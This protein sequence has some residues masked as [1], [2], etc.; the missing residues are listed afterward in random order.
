[1]LGSPKEVMKKSFQ[2]KL[3]QDDVWLEMLKIRN[4][5]SHDYDGV[6]IKKP[7]EK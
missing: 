5:L 4:E 1:M 3:I 6:I 2:V 7:A